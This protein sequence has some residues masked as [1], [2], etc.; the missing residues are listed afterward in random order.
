[1]REA[2]ASPY[3]KVEEAAR[4]LRLRKRTLDNL[5]WLGGGPKFRKHG[6]RIVYHRDDLTA[7]SE[8]NL[9]RSTSEA[10]P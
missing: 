1:M 2:C 7:W 10:G 8:K 3:L 5:R 4:F 9:R 6:G